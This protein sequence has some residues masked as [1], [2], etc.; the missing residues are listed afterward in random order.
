[1]VKNKEAS[2]VRRGNPGN[3][4]SDGAG[5]AGPTGSPWVKIAVLARQGREANGW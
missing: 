1:L 2:Q 3:G 5:P 4:A